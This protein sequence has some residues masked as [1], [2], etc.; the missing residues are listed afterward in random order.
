M[1]KYLNIAIFILI[2]FIVGISFLVFSVSVAVVTFLAVVVGMSVLVVPITWVFALAT[3]QTYDRI[4]DNSEILYRLNQIGKWSLVF[5]V[6]IFLT[7]III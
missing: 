3:G 4:C 5:C 6:G 1:K 2:L 7:W